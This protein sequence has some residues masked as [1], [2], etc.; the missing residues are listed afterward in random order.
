MYFIQNIRP[1]IVTKK[2]NLPHPPQKSKNKP[3]TENDGK[4]YIIAKER[5]IEISWHCTCTYK[6]IP[7]FVSSGLICVFYVHGYVI[8]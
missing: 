3:K 7:M 6:F 8:S 5:S 2:K 1:D 4:P